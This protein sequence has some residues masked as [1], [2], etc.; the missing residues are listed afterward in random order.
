M[1]NNFNANNTFYSQWNIEE[2]SIISK[3]MY[4]KFGCPKIFSPDELLEM[5]Q[6]E[7]ET[8]YM[9]V[10]YSKDEIVKNY[11]LA[12]KYYNQTKL[13]DNENF[14]EEE[15]LNNIVANWNNLSEITKAKD[16]SKTSDS[17]PRSFLDYIEKFYQPKPKQSSD[18]HNNTHAA[19]LAH[20]YTGSQNPSTNE[21]DNGYGGHGMN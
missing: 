4:R 13:K 14:N 11:N 21:A 12:I 6:K 7:A 1:G 15:T 2:L 3:L 18:T 8:L 20:Y 10:S 16:N 19:I 5:D 17:T 9:S